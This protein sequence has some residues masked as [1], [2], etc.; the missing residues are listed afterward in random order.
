MTE[1]LPA[2]HGPAKTLSRN[3]DSHVTAP[4]QSHPSHNYPHIPRHSP[5]QPS[6]SHVTTPHRATAAPSQHPSHPPSQPVTGPSQPRHSPTAAS[7]RPKLVPT[8][9]LQH[10]I[11]AGEEQPRGCAKDSF[12]AYRGERRG[13]VGGRRRV[14]K[15]TGRRREVERG[16]REL[17]GGIEPRLPSLWAAVSGAHQMVPENNS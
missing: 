6:H 2:L 1:P 17:G 15:K 8:Y 14:Y 11:P 10:S 4:S 16:K 13:G 12:C 9:R 3:C 5:A 7:P